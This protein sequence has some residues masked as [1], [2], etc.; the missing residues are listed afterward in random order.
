MKGTAMKT[1][2]ATRRA[3][4]GFAMFEA[5]VALL[6]FSFGILGLLGLQARAIAT[7]GDADNRNRAALI[8]DRC[9][10]QMQLQAAQ[11]AMTS[12]A[13]DLAGICATDAWRRY[14]SDPKA[15]G[16]P[17]G[18]I[19]ITPPA[20]YDVVAGGAPL[21]PVSVGIVIQWKPP[22]RAADA[23]ASKL[24]TTATLLVQNR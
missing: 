16:L 11:A 9:V 3:H 14:V 18:A 21:A 7:E 2:T 15:G 23:A 17:G 24:T 5:L 19:T 4:A 20:A 10:S 1:R 6:L 12:G 8:A 22:A 13:S